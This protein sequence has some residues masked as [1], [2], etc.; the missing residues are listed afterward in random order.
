MKIRALLL[1][2]KALR[3][4]PSRSRFH[5]FFLAG[6]CMR[7]A[8]VVFASFMFFA[9]SA[10]VAPALPAESLDR[11]MM[12]GGQWSD[13]NNTTT[14]LSNLTDLPAVVEVYT[15]TWCENCV[16]VEHALDEVQDAGLIEQ[17]HIH[18]AI[19]ETQ[20]PFGSEAIDAR[21]NSK[22]G[23]NAPPAVVFNGTL[24]KSGSVT[25][26]ASLADEFTGLA[27]T[28]LALGGGTTS[29]GWTPTTASSGTV[30]WNLNIDDSH[31]EGSTLNV[32]A[33]IVEAAAEFEEG[34]NGLGT[35]PHIVLDIISLGDGLQGSVAIQLPDAND[36]NDL[37]VHLIYEIMPETVD[38]VVEE[39]D[40]DSEDSESVPFLT[41]FATATALLG[42]AWA[43]GGKV[44]QKDLQGRRIQ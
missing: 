28:D 4:E 3:N 12:F 22:Y 2:K 14:D 41:T 23:Q 39:G 32:T 10:P 16:D 7:R 31:L 24:K 29:F 1:L 30:T 5:I 9:L 44:N 33:W 34:S 20:D 18:R 35:Y 6:R 15:A 37:Q 38:P 19:G 27:N 11:G 25:N 21:W 40:D 43:R 17:Y 26:E 36:G 42:A 8:L 13:A